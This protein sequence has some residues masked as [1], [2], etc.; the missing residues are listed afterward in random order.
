MAGESFNM[1]FVPFWEHDRPNK[2]FP[3]YLLWARRG[4]LPA[5]VSFPKKRRNL[6][7]VVFLVHQN[8]DVLQQKFI[9]FT[10]TKILAAFDSYEFS[11]M[12]CATL[13]ERLKWRYAQ[14]GRWTGT[15]KDQRAEAFAQK[16]PCKW[17]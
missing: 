11:G 5:P 6:P 14:R 3:D 1:T 12:L 15:G 9:Y 2:K 7:S 16:T 17:K 10:R 8:F 4:R 13:V